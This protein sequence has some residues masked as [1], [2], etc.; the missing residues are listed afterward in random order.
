MGRGKHR[1]YVDKHSSDHL[2]CLVG[3]RPGSDFAE[4]AK[5]YIDSIR[6]LDVISF[7]GL[8]TEKMLGG[9]WEKRTLAFRRPRNATP[10]PIPSGAFAGQ[11]VPQAVQSYSSSRFAALIYG[12]NNRV[13]FDNTF[14]VDD[15]F[16][17]LFQEITM[18][19]QG[20]AFD[21][22]FISTIFPRADDLDECNRIKSN[23]KLFNDKM[24]SLVNRRCDRYKIS[25]KNRDGVDQVVHWVPIDMTDVLPYHE[26]HNQ[27][28]FCEKNLRKRN[29]DQI[30]VNAKYL[31]V[32][33]RKLDAAI[34]KYK[35]NHKLRQAD[36][37]KNKK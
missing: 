10:W 6:P 25:I 17:M 18:L 35:R 13:F 5:A 34:Q 24:L 29:T 11:T 37:R 2:D 7:S 8:N 33:Y 32:Y 20:S 1:S 3:G 15:A 14:S 9:F 26:M 30:H 19:L 12:S 22:I 16:S 21:V 28:Y 31:E 4:A 27:K 23:V 36:N